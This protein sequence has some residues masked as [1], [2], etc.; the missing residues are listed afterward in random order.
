M[1]NTSANRSICSSGD[2]F[3]NCLLVRIGKGGSNLNIV[4]CIYRQAEII[5]RYN[6]CFSFMYI[7]I[8]NCLLL[9]VWHE[10]RN[11]N[12]KIKRNYNI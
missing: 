1:S 11:N 3:K 10:N 8:T 5:I 12:N 2:T 6:N 4:M 7:F 9:V